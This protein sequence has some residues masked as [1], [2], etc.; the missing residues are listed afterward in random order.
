M[1]DAP[2]DVVGSRRTRSEAKRD[3]SRSLEWGYPEPGDISNQ[4]KRLQE[5]NQNHHEHDYVEKT[6]DST[7]HG[8]IG[9]D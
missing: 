2:L 6:L 3:T 4:A 1:Q 9:I 5:P 8:N 7:G